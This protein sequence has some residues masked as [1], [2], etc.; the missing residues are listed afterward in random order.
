MLGFIIVFV[1]NELY[2]LMNW[3]SRELYR[4]LFCASSKT[5]LLLA[6]QQGF[7]RRTSCKLNLATSASVPYV[8]QISVHIVQVRP[9]LV[10][11]NSFSAS[12]I[13]CDSFTYDS[14]KT[15]LDKFFSLDT[16]LRCTTELPFPSKTTII[17]IV[18]ITLGY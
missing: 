16:K 14:S 5:F 4:P 12:M 7:G 9:A 2:V 6:L 1:P 8:Q 18:Q 15:A 10:M 17:I 13:G 3:Q 11:S